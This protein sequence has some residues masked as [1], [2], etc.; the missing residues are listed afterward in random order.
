MK[1]ELYPIDSKNVYKSTEY[2]LA[3]NFHDNICYVNVVRSIYSMNSLILMSHSAIRIC[4][5]QIWNVFVY[6]CLGDNSKTEEEEKERKK[7][8]DEDDIVKRNRMSPHQKK[9]FYSFYGIFCLSFFLAH[10]RRWWEGD[11]KN[12]VLL[13]LSHITDGLLMRCCMPMS[14]FGMRTIFD[15]HAVKGF[16]Y[17]YSIRNI[18]L[19]PKKKKEDRIW[20]SLYLDI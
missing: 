17:Y 4:Y 8:N 19:W 3:I 20:L 2:H 9:D 18:F 15:I 6:M 14:P 13:L 12:H 7:N 5:R 1:Y 11:K 10:M 16:Y